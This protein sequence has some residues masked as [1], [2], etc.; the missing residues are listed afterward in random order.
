MLCLLLF[1]ASKKLILTRIIRPWN[2][3]GIFYYFFY[4]FELFS[5]NI[6]CNYNYPNRDFSSTV[7][8][9]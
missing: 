6:T 9:L 5:W 3:K 4:F 1:S 8:Y 2:L 7:S